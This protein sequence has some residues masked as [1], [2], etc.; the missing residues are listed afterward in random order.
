M[1]DLNSDEWYADETVVKISGVKHYLWFVVDSETRF[2]I[3]YHLSSQGF[4]PG[5]FCAS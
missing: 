4:S 3:G 1:L 5:C 2:V